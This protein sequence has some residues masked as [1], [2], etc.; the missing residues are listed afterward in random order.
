M[1][2]V[3]IR[4]AAG[5]RTPFWRLSDTLLDVRGS[6]VHHSQICLF[7]FLWDISCFKLVIFKKLKTQN[8]W[9]LLSC[10]KEFGQRDLLQASC[11]VGWNC[12]LVRVGV[13]CAPSWKSAQQTLVSLA[14]A[15]PPPTGAARLAPRSSRRWPTFSLAGLPE[16]SSRSI[17]SWN[18]PHSVRTELNLVL[19]C[20]QSV[21]SVSLVGC[22]EPGVETEIS[23]APHTYIPCFTHLSVDGHTAISCFTNFTHY[24][25]TSCNSM[26]NFGSVLNNRSRA[27]SL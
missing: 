16:L 3:F 6:R 26:W 7:F 2:A 14:F 12:S 8:L 11:R 22:P 23:P 10:L 17:F 21:V 4:V 20:C 24:V 18:S 27:Y 15:F 13:L 5:V 1:S 9:P 19:F 25:L